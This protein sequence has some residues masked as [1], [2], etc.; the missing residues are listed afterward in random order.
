MINQGAATGD[1]PRRRNVT[2][3]GTGPLTSEAMALAMSQPILG[4]EPPRQY[5]RFEDDKICT[6]LE[7]AAK[8]ADSASTAVQMMQQQM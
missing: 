1:Q 6:A 5:A 7:V 2:E 4:E 8:A 3:S